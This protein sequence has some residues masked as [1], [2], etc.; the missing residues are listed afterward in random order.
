M[1]SSRSSRRRIKRKV[2]ELEMQIECEV[3]TGCKSHNIENMNL[4]VEDSL[5]DSYE[6]EGK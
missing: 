6:G 1:S 3:E 5:A 4:I 2:D